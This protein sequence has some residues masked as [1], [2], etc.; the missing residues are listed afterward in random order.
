MWNFSHAAIKFKE[1]YK[2]IPVLI[3]D[4]AS[5][6]S[7]RHQ[8]LLEQ[9]QDYA[10]YATDRGIA[11]VVFVSNESYLPL[12]MRG[13]LILFVVLFINCSVLIKYYREELVV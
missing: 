2:K 13:N 10:K 9:F 8:D 1:K 12:H 7:V 4:N 6:L 11:T 3:I 5:R